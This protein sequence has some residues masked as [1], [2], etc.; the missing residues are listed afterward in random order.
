MDKE[1]ERLRGKERKRIKKSFKFCCDTLKWYSIREEADF[2][3]IDLA[4]RSFTL[5]IE[6]AVHT[7]IKFCP[8]CGSQLPKYLYD[9]WERILT[10]EYGIQTPS[11]HMDDD[12]FPPE[13][14]TEEWWKK[15]GL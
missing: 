14:L 2:L 15:R 9:E 4:T 11:A 8:W 10:Q 5:K 3:R 6:K 7:G 13:F 12:G 1:F